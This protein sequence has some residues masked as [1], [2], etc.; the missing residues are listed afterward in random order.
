[1]IISEASQN[2][3]E[4]IYKLL[5]NF[6]NNKITKK[7]WRRA[8]SSQVL[9]VKLETEAGE[10]V[11]FLGWVEKEI[12]GIRYRNLS[13][14]IIKEEYR[15]YALQVLKT[16]INDGYV[17]SD[18]TP[19]SNATKILKAFKF[20]E[21]E[22][23][24]LL[25]TKKWPLKKIDKEIINHFDE[26]TNI[27]F[28]EKSGLTIHYAINTI[29]VSEA[30][31]SLFE[32]LH[33]LREKDS[34]QKH[35]RSIHILSCLKRLRL[36]PAKLVRLMNVLTS[37]H[38]CR[39]IHIDSRLVSNQDLNLF[40]IYKLENKRLVKNNGEIGDNYGTEFHF[41]KLNGHQYLRSN[42]FLEL[43]REKEENYQKLLTNDKFIEDLNLEIRTLEKILR[44]KKELMSDR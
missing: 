33:F 5:F 31:I 13:S 6:D 42:R 32:R 36:S 21:A 39:Y 2:D 10:I 16:A 1:M 17:Y 8:F 40:R 37:I 38:S 12:D 22:D 34:S 19:S 30:G 41:L 25:F 27:G 23:S 29:C 4:K 14:W 24:V 15:S 20:N 35:V 11:G 18:L 44:V 26:S 43:A 3:F 28:F 7:D 9:G